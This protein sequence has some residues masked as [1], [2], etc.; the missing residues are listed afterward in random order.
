MRLDRIGDALAAGA[1]IEAGGIAIRA[2][3]PAWAK[4]D[5][6]GEAKAPA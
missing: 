5:W 1:T 4:F 3:K 2:V 6:P